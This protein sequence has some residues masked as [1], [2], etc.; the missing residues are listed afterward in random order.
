ML[1]QRLENKIAQAAYRPKVS[2]PA[3]TNYHSKTRIQPTRLLV[4]IL[5]PY[6]HE[7]S[8]FILVQPF[9]IVGSQNRRLQCP[10]RLIWFCGL[11][12]AR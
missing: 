1:P 10:A 9:M 8:L 11:Q 3:A 7:P 6:T 2:H 12:E 4:R 5:I